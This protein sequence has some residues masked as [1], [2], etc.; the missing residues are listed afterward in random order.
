M[1][2]GHALL[3]DALPFGV[4]QGCDG[5]IRVGT[6]KFDIRDPLTSPHFSYAL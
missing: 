4:G 3:E 1:P 2:A 6:E 5:K